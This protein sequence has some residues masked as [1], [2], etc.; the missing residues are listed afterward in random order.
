MKARQLAKLIVASKESQ[1][2]KNS[3]RAGRSTDLGRVRTIGLFDEKK[4]SQ[5][6]KI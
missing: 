6:L 3:K 2:V 4:N 5:L 1:L